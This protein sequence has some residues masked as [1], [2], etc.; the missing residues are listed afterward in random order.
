MIENLN[1][2]CQQQT[3]LPGL[4]GIVSALLDTRQKFL[5]LESPNV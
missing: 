4:D 1:D 3:V 2:K 5:Q